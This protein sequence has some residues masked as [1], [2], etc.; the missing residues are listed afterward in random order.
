M[1]A[2]I[3]EI[4]REQVRYLLWS[5]RQFPEYGAPEFGKDFDQELAAYFQSHYRPVRQLVP[6]DGQA[7]NAVIWERVPGGSLD[8]R[9]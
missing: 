1:D 8:A 3:G 7:W 2:L 9:R 4:E 6:A 5:D